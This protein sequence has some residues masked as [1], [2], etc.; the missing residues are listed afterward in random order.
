MAYQQTV[1]LPLQLLLVL[2]MLLLSPGHYH[3]CGSKDWSSISSSN[4]NI[5]TIYFWIIALTPYPLSLTPVPQPLHVLDVLLIP[6]LL[7]GVRSPVLPA[8]CNSLDIQICWNVAEMSLDSQKI[9]WTSKTVFGFPTDVFKQHGPD[10]ATISVALLAL[11]EVY[12]QPIQEQIGID[13]GLIQ[14][15]LRVALLANNKSL[16]LRVRFSFSCSGFL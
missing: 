3:T 15:W 14:V 4:C 11:F 16:S 8:P 1:V 5:S 6:S 12:W 7:I 10:L 9:P 2:L 13:S